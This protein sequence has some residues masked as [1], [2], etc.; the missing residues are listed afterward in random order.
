MLS[1]VMNALKTGD[2]KS[3][4]TVRKIKMSKIVYKIPNKYSG[5]WGVL[6]VLLLLLLLIVVVV[7]VVVVV[8]VVVV[9]VVIV[10]VVIVV[11]Y[12]MQ[13]R[14]FPAHDMKANWQ[15]RKS[16]HWFPAW[17]LDGSLWSASRSCFFNPLALE[18]DIYSLAYHLCKM[19]IFYEPRRVTLGD[20]RHFVEE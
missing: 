12:I 5:K 2:S 1:P 17:T 16:R 15:T 10:V 7:L 20:T 6:S 19:W 13:S 11:V 4:T 14:I 18:L 8:I 3:V 9:V